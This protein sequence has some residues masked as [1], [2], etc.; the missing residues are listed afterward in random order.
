MAPV[1][2]ITII[3]IAFFI[4]AAIIMWR[5][6]KKKVTN[7]SIGHIKHWL[8]G[9]LILAVVMGLTWIFGVLIVEAKELSPMAFIYAFLVAFQGVWLFLL[10][11]VLDR[12]V[13]EGY[14]KLWRTKVKQSDF[15]NSFFGKN[16]YTVS[17]GV[18]SDQS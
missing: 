2:L 3:N 5:I 9:L 1:I 16:S 14:A 6:S 15:Y 4:M 8:R 13:R 17:S 18:V 10:F 11:V 12:Q 7:S